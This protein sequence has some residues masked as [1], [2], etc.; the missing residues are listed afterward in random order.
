MQTK[1]FYPTFSDSIA[2]AWEKNV[3]N[4]SI[5]CQEVYQHLTAD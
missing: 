1:Y 5:N 4:Y 3:A 2:K